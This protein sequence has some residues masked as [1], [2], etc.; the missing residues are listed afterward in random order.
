M[1]VLSESINAFKLDP[2]GVD[3]YHR[4]YQYKVVVKFQSINR[5][6]YYNSVEKFNERL[7]H[8]IIKTELDI[9]SV[10][11]RDGGSIT[12]LEKF[13]VWR[14]SNKSKEYKMMICGNYLTFYFN[15]T[16]S[17]QSF[18][19]TFNLI[20]RGYNR[21]RILNHQNGVV[22]LKK[23]THR[24]RVYLKDHKLTTSENEALIN[25]FNEYGVKPSP[26]LAKVVYKTSG[27][28]Y[29]YHRYSW[30]HSTNF[31]DIP[32]DST[33]TV[34]GLHIPHLIRKICSIV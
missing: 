27:R 20:W 32:D 19:D 24:W 14:N 6:R 5:A 10:I 3:L 17:I 29:I 2:S 34:T 15:D 23:P 7:N 21:Q 30:V 9:R 13:I 12:D 1:T 26:S 16:S 33:L 4:K 8:T 28:T 25:L 31:F 11:L 22:Y 18:F